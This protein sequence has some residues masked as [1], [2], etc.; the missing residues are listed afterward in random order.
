MPSN[1][2][3][4]RG[5]VYFNRLGADGY[6][7]FRY[8]GNTPSFSMTINTEDLDHYSSDEGL[9]VK[10][11]SVTLSVDYA[12]SLTTDSISVENVALMFFG[13]VRAVTQASA[14]AKTETFTVSRGHL[15]ELP[16]RAVS[17]VVVKKGTQT[18]VEGIDYLL[19][20][21]NGDIE[22]PEDS[23]VGARDEI[24]VTYNQSAVRYDRILSGTTPIAGQLLFK[25]TNPVGSKIGYRL[26]KV[27]LRPNGEYQLKGDEWQQISFNVE[28]LSQNGNPEIVGTSSTRAA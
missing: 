26:E 19:D 17:D 20:A 23:S 13:D 28:V 6:E 21:D 14:T 4:G 3:I 9:K 25:A 8:L 7:G 11:E 16:A 10:D 12:A 5:K 18:L 24:T 2:T 15:Y 1:T 27:I 22:I